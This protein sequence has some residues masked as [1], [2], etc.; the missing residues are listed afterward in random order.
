MQS[1]EQ[2]KQDLAEL[3]KKYFGKTVIANYYQLGMEAKRFSR[4]LKRPLRTDMPVE[5]SHV[6]AINSQ[7]SNCGKLYEVDE[8]KT[9][10]WQEKLAAH[11]VNLEK[12][13][14]AEK[15]GAKKLS[16]A[17]AEIGNDAD[18]P[19]PGFVTRNAKTW[20]VDADLRYSELEE[21]ASA[22]DYLFTGTKQECKDYV[23]SEKEKS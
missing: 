8:D 18:E 7:W 17:L 16:Q 4:D 2:F 19:A 20:G 14:K 3:E 21:G 5:M 11:K 10:A 13:D 22:S 12:R 9:A 1:E 15:I 6:A 23:K